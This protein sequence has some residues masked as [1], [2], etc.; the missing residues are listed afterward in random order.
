VNKKVMVQKNVWPKNEE[1]THGLGPKYRVYYLEMQ[2]GGPAALPTKR[3][4][5]EKHVSPKVFPHDENAGSVR[6]STDPGRVLTILRVTAVPDRQE[7]NR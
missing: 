1:V 3:R 7:P 5:Q 6:R 4:R 2:S